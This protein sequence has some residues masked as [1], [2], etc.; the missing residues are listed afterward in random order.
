VDHLLENWDDVRS[1]FMNPIFLMSDFDGTLVPIV[2]RPENAVLSEDM[3][4]L[5]KQ[6]LSFSPVAIISGRAI[7]DLKDKVDIEGVYYS[8]N[9]G[10]EIIGPGISFVKNRAKRAREIIEKICNEIEG[11]FK[12][13]MDGLIVENKKYTASFHYRLLG[14][15]DERKLKEILNQKTEPYRKK[16]IIEINH[17][18]KILEIVPSI[19]W[20]KG[21]AVSLLLKVAGFEEEIMPIYLG[22]DVTDEHAFS[23]IQRTGIGILVSEERRETAAD[24]R[25]RDTVEVKKFLERLSEVLK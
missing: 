23:A 7:D 2:D 4:S 14:K 24:F 6:L 19:K 9:H 11:E 17:G 18:K 15:S 16:N 25:L 20:N 8:G 12:D 5:L 1:I 3:R 10:F 22:D 21:K 13:H